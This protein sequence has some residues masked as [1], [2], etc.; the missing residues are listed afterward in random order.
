MHTVYLKFYTIIKLYLIITIDS[1]EE[2]ENP[3]EKLLLINLSST[4]VIT[5]LCKNEFIDLFFVYIN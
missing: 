3:G 1:L 2:L 4:V 5:I